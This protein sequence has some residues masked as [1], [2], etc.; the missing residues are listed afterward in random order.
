MISPWR[1]MHH[2]KP[3]WLPSSTVSGSMHMRY[4][5]KQQAVEAL[6]RTWTVNTRAP[7]C[8]FSEAIGRKS[9]IKLVRIQTREKQQYTAPAAFYVSYAPLNQIFFISVLF[10]KHSFS[11]IN[12]CSILDIVLQTMLSHPVSK[13]PQL[14]NFCQQLFFFC[15]CASPS[16]NL[17]KCTGEAFDHCQQRKLYSCEED[18]KALS[19]NNF[20]VQVTNAVVVQV[21]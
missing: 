12:H 18:A 13:W 6:A 20:Y 3:T 11:S 19:D 4:D 7:Q 15:V 2:Q 9:N 16:L 1:K 17:N 8:V 14:L 10:L 21:L 5:H